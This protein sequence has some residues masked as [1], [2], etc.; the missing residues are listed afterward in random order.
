MTPLSVEPLLAIA[1]GAVPQV[2]S[3]DPVEK[4]PFGQ[5]STGI[6]AGPPPPEVLT[7]IGGVNVGIYVFVTVHVLLSLE[8]RSILPLESQDPLKLGV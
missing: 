1:I 2:P 3:D 8:E 4:S 6:A 5:I 7:I